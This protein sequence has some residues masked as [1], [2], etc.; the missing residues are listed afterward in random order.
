MNIQRGAAALAAVV[1]LAGEAR[2]SDVTVQIVVPAGSTGAD[3]ANL[4]DSNWSQTG[5]FGCDADLNLLFATDLLGDCTEPRSAYE[6]QPQLGMTVLPE[7]I[8][9]RLQCSS[10]LDAYIDFNGQ[11][12]VQLAAGP[13]MFVNGPD[14]VN[15]FFT[16]CAAPTTSAFE[17]IRIGSPPNP[18]A[19]FPGVTN[20]PLIGLTWD[21]VIDHT[22]FLPS[23]TIDVLGIS[24]TPLN[25]FAPSYGTVL[26]SAAVF[27]FL[28]PPGV[29]FSVRIPAD[30]TLIGLSVC[31][32]GASWNGAKL[33][34][35]NAID[36]TF[37]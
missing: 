13:N 22:C 9:L 18:P 32:Q 37:L 28:S 33:K 11:G 16:V 21:P 12:F 34:L 15:I 17:S 24:T 26:C 31:T 6:F 3:I 36:V 35:T 10:P 30:P 5:A 14:V 20:P 29:P 8:K 25:F 23:A 4:F 27:S 1:L 2:A 19:F 7:T